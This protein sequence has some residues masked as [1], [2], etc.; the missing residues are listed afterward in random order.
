MR[1]LKAEEYRNRN[2]ERKEKRR[3]DNFDNMFHSIPI[4][5]TEEQLERMKEWAKNTTEI[6]PTLR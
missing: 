2:R 3:K 4:E 5:F 6:K 1:D